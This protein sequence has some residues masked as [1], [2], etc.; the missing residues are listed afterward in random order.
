MFLLD[1][2]GTCD[3]PCV[4][5]VNTATVTVNFITTIIISLEFLLSERQAISQIQL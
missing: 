1:S 4:I 5:H 2:P 3:D